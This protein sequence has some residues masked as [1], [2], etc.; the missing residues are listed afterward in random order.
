M[1]PKTYAEIIRSADEMP[2][3][4]FAARWMLMPEAESIPGLDPADLD[5]SKKVLASLHKRIT[6]SLAEIRKEAGLSQQKL[7]DRFAIPV[8][9]VRT[10]EQRDC[11]P[12]YTRLM[13]QELLG[14]WS[15]EKDMGVESKG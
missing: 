9:T 7:A 10:W 1:T 15:P 13:I 14:Q 5:K 3:E 2:A 8:G 4:L 12:I 11:C 6:R